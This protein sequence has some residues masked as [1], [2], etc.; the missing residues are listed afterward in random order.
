MIISY[1]SRLLGRRNTTTQQRQN[2]SYSV[3]SD[4]D[5]PAISISQQM[6]TIYRPGDV[7][8]VRLP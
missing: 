3:D 7:S 5:F 6:L 4:L 1:L 2:S 8:V